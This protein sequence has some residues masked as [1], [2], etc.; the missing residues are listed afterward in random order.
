MKANNPF[1]NNEFNLKSLK[2]EKMNN[3]ENQRPGNVKGIGC[4]LLSIIRKIKGYFK[5]EPTLSFGL[6]EEALEIQKINKASEF[7]KI[8][9]RTEEYA[10]KEE[11]P[12]DR[13]RKSS[14]KI[15]NA[16]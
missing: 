8:E 11:T 1:I 2:R 5:K 7:D 9:E 15:E 6:D 12:P 14:I 10:S 3:D 16:F 13:S 4:F